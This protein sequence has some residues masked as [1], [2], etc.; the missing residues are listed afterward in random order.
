[1]VGFVAGNTTMV[2]AMGTCAAC[3]GSTYSAT[4]LDDASCCQAHTV[5]GSSQY[6][7]VAGT[8]QNNSVCADK[9]PDGDTCLHDTQCTNTVCKTGRCCDKSNGVSAGCLAC[10]PDGQCIKC[11]NGNK[12]ENIL[13]KLVTGWRY[14]REC[15]VDDV[16]VKAA[17]D[18]IEA[19]ARAKAEA[20]RIAKEI[21][22]K[23]AAD[24]AVAE[25]LA[26]AKADTD[27]K[28]AAKAVADAKAAE[29]NAKALADKA[30]V[31]AK[32]NAEKAIADANAKAVLD[33]KAAADK[34]V[35]DAKAKADAKAD[36]E[37]A[38]G[39][40]VIDAQNKAK[41]DAKATVDKEKEDAKAQLDVEVEAAADAKKT[42][43]A[44]AVEDAKAVADIDAAAAAAATYVYTIDGSLLFT[45]IATPDDFTPAMQ[46]GLKTTLAAKC[47]A[48]SDNVTLVVTAVRRRRYQRH[49][50]R[51]LSSGG[52]VNVAYSIRV[53]SK[54]AADQGK[55][56]LTAI[57][58]GGDTAV[59]SFIA[60]LKANA[61]HGT[62]AFVDVDSITVTAPVVKSTMTDN[63]D[64]SKSS[65]V[66]NLPIVAIAAGAGGGVVFIAVI[67]AVLVCRRRTAAN[68]ARSGGN[69]VISP[70]A[71]S[72]AASPAAADETANDE[73]SVELSVRVV[74]PI[75][76]ART[77]SVGFDGD[78]G[79]GGPD[80]AAEPKAARREDVSSTSWT[81]ALR[82]EEKKLR[83]KKEEFGLDTVEKARLKFLARV[84]RKKKRS[85]STRRLIARESSDKAEAEL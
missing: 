64:K 40:A 51:R 6:V 31:D 26:A 2:G 11:S 49:Q 46:A 69:A 39:K 53:D 62:F 43:K 36:A 9:K 24:K 75:I 83:A 44:K 15:V 60:A 48:S 35:A 67:I 30:A 1:M 7:S 28:F 47:G 3:T 22:D 19:E 41:L 34:A 32:A 61:P 52:G 12:L 38:A 54:Q 72:S 65:P 73:R 59:I 8:S 14:N 63:G 84:K 68:R 55:E 70:R 50:R 23:A 82:L 20:D 5:C 33:Q 29:A 21:V 17:S 85:D 10:G 74:N 13:S 71:S 78:D 42:A 25:K 81:K 66:G 37:A 77:Q 45:A 18:K 27:A 76:L 16:A 57:S 58:A 80:E 79:G 56:A 4:S